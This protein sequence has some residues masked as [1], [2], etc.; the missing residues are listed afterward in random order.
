MEKLPGSRNVFKSK[1]TTKSSKTDKPTITSHK[2]EKRYTSKDYSD[3][4][5]VYDSEN[6]EAIFRIDR[7]YKAEWEEEE[8][9]IKGVEYI[10]WV[11]TYGLDPQIR[12][13]KDYRSYSSRGGHVLSFSIS[14]KENEDFIV[15]KD[16]VEK[17]LMKLL[18][19][20]A[21][22]LPV[23]YYAIGSKLWRFLLDLSKKPGNLVRSFVET[24][25]P[26]IPLNEM[27]MMLKSI[28]KVV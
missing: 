27:K 20:H 21:V 12:T 3:P 8:W 7:N 22:S 11:Y 16:K 23:G 2:K 17:W 4:R 28:E 19:N 5:V 1:V 25:D 6:K 9:H 10:A 15:V 18:E 13:L 26:S 24:V 14:V